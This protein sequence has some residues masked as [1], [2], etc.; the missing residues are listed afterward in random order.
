MSDD[1]SD[2]DELLNSSRVEAGDSDNDNNDKISE[3]GSDNDAPIIGKRSR[4]QSEI[5]YKGEDLE[6]DDDDDESDGSFGGSD[7]DSDGSGNSDKNSDENNN[8]DDNDD[9][10]TNLFENYSK[11]SKKPEKKKSKLEKTKKK[12]SA[13]KTR[14]YEDAAAV[15]DDDEEEE[16]DMNNGERAEEIIPE[17]V[18]YA[19]ER[20]A[21]R[22][23]KNKAFQSA[24]AHE[25]AQQFEERHQQELLRKKILG[26]GSYMSGEIGV[27]GKR[28]PVLQQSLLPSIYSDPGIYRVKVETGKE[29]ML[30]RSILLK[31]IDSKLKGGPIRIKSVFCG[32][33]RKYIYIEAIAEPFAREALVGLHGILYLS[34]YLKFICIISLFILNNI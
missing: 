22:H 17:D 10:N 8:S 16:E 2:N 31:A 19:N 9:N 28:N 1:G 7:D 24:S 6:E 26:S 11:K 33:N 34:N 3:V 20:V 29:Q 4:K 18:R 21:Q 23:E 13:S 32:T 15:A 12:K 5:V 27:N 14:F 30:C 25:L